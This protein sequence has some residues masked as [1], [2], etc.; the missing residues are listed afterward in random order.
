M[1]T[2][3]AIKIV[4]LIIALCG[5]FA[6]LPLQAS[7][8]DDFTFHQIDSEGHLYFSWKTTS[9]NEIGAILQFTGGGITSMWTSVWLDSSW[10][11]QDRTH[12]KADPL[13]DSPSDLAGKTLSFRAQADVCTAYSGDTC[14]AASTSDWA[15]LDVSFD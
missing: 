9:S 13:T 11:D 2:R 7:P 1:Q 8:P 5:I 4:S 6:A 10:F 14:I 15:Y 12:I 3:S